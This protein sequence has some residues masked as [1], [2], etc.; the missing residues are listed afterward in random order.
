MTRQEYRARILLVDDHP[1]DLTLVES[2]L[3]LEGFE[4]NT[5]NSDKAAL[6]RLGARRPDLVVTDLVGPNIDGIYLLREIHCCDPVI[7]VIFTSGE[8]SIPEA[9]KATHL[10][11]CAFLT[12]PLQRES[13]IAEVRRSLTT[14]SGGDAHRR[15][16]FAPE[17]IY[18]SQVMAE[19]LG[20]ARLLAAVDTT[21]QITGDTGTG[22]EVLAKAIHAASRRSAA[23]FVAINCSALPKALLESELFGHEKGSFSGAATRHEGLF[24]FANGGTLFLDEIGDMS[25]A[26]QAKLLRVLQD[27]KVRPIGS[28]AA[29]PIDVRVIS[30]TQQNLDSLIAQGNFREDL[31]YRL[32]VVPLHMPSLR[33]HRE[34]IPL[35]AD[36]FLRVVGR[37]LGKPAKRFAPDAL[38]L[39]LAA[40]LP[41]NVRQ[42]SNLVEQCSVLCPYDVVPESFTAQALHE[43]PAEHLTFDNANKSFEHRYLTNVLKVSQGNVANAARIA[44]RPRSEFYRLLAL[45]NLDPK[46]FRPCTPCRGCK[47]KP[48]KFLKVF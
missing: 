33:E 47:P 19:L 1:L 2:W 32:S 24:Q 39:L 21:V 8:A 25:L 18:R 5:S 29:I 15:D 16:P 46:R 9:V 37:R 3:T 30:A 38:R 31:F 27:S 45:H 7:P 42:L 17:I 44:K 10:G 11:A 13:F 4:V 41:G 26:S 14:Q 22:K 36:H 28:A 20:R 34:D 12:K 35:L 23:P 6:A 40:D 48:S 43:E